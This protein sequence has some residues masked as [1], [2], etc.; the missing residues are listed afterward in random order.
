MAANTQNG[1]VRTGRRHSSGG[2]FCF[3]E[4]RAQHYNVTYRNVDHVGPNPCC[5]RNAF[6]VPACAF[7]V[8]PFNNSDLYTS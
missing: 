7:S 6:V 8:S 2:V 5:S 3:A 4:P 1:H